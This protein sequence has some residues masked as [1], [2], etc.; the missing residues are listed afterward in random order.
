MEDP[1]RDLHENTT[2]IYPENLL[3]ELTLNHKMC[4]FIENVNDSI[5]CNHPCLANLAADETGEWTRGFIDEFVNVLTHKMQIGLERLA[6]FEVINHEF[7]TKIVTNIIEDFHDHNDNCQYPN[8]SSETTQK[9]NGYYKPAPSF[10]SNSVKIR[11]I[12]KIRLKFRIMEKAHK[13][14]LETLELYF[15]MLTFGITKETLIMF[16]RRVTLSNIIQ[17]K[18]EENLGWCDSSGDKLETYFDGFRILA[19]FGNRTRYFVYVNATDTIYSTGYY[20][21]FIMLT[22]NGYDL[23]QGFKLHSNFHE[24]NSPSTFILKI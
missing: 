13:E 3:V 16:G 20:Y 21:M 9:P 22:T 8:Q 15:Q 14:E 10:Y 4:M 12:E 5:T 23:T 17:S 6:N 24:I 2:T 1:E 7:T 19:S 18:S 11:L